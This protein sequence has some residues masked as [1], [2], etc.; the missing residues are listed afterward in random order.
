VLILLRRLYPYW[1]TARRDAWCGIA[2]LMLAGV[3][4]LLQPWPIKWLVDYVFGGRPAPVALTTF[5][6]RTGP[7]NSV[8]AVA[9]VCGA[10]VVLA[11]AHKSAQMLSQLLLIRS[12]LH[13]VRNL[14]ARMSE[15]LHQLSLR[16]HDRTKV[17][18]SIYRAAYDS[19]AAQSLL[20][21]VV[22]PVATGLV[23][24]TGIL[25]VMVRLDAVLAAIAL[26]VAPLL[27]LTIWS[28]GRG[29]ERQ[30]RRYHEQESALYCTLQETL[31]A[32]RF[33][34][35][36]TREAQTGERVWDQAGMSMAASQRLAL[37]QLSFSASVGL[38]MAAGT[39]AAVYVGAT[40][41]IEGRLLLGDVL[42]F[43][44]YLGML[45]SPV[46]AFAQS[47]GVLR[48]ARTQLVRVFEV[49]ETPPEVTDRPGTFALPRVR[50]SVE[51]RDVGFSYEPGRWALRGL[52]V[53]VPALSV[54][55]LVG[56]TGAGKSTLA[57]LLLRLYD[58]DEGTVLLD[59]HD[60]RELKL[61]W[62]RRQIALV[63]QDAILL[64]GTISE[65]IGFG[66]PGATREEIEEAARRAQADGFIRGLPDGYETLLGERGVNL[67]GGQRQRLSLA[68]AFLKNAPLLILDEPTSALDAQTESALLD[69]MRDLM[70]DRTTLIIAHRLSTIRNAD[71][72]LVMDRGRV[73]ERGSHQ[74]LL[75]GE[76]IYRRLYEAQWK[77]DDGVD[78]PVSSPSAVAGG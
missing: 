22:A 52:D 53:D 58:P 62:L 63:P 77:V 9:W 56:S 64:S 44:A 54:V 35:A 32:I 16:Y 46:N 71:S 78:G 23:I 38:T 19:F 11:V 65:N 45:Y 21:G 28:F 17:G 74:V 67:S 68:R 75:R 42:V 31:S 47:S 37:L 10:I 41:V 48:S 30:S 73:V 59:G 57:S 3:L 66:R 55:A 26:L 15:H 4:E 39:A 29:I 24:L 40:R 25:V 13:L 27:G 69:S 61:D 72:I 76:T 70:K 51:F 49:L 5:G 14:R 1:R 36:Y 34:Q 8:L 20:S 33:I 43:L 60:L 12:G 2:L 18:D 50:G 6:F 7:A